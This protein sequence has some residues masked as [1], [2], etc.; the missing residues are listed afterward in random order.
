MNEYQFQPLGSERL[1][2]DK[3][4]R[5]G[6]HQKEGAALHLFEGKQV[7]RQQL[8]GELWL[9]ENGLRSGSHSRSFHGRQK[10]AGRRFATRRWLTMR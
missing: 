9:R 8:D 7:L 5:L 2:P 3:V 4:I 10:R 1:G 6:F